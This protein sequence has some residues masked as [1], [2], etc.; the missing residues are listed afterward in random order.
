MDILK[1][2]KNISLGSAHFA[3]YND[4]ILER[5]RNIV[6]THTLDNFDLGTLGD[7][8]VSGSN[9]S[10]TVVNL[11][12]GIVLEGVQDVDAL[13]KGIVQKLPLK[14][15]QIMNRKEYRPRR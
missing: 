1:G 11:N 8:E 14:M 4:E 12:G 5:M 2:E 9:N 3:G 6:S 15:M 7:Y 10:N 13:A